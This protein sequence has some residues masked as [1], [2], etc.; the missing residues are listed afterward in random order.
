MAEGY[1]LDD[2]IS[3]PERLQKFRTDHPTWALRSETV[4]LTDKWVTVHAWVEDDK[5]VVVGDGHAEEMRKRFSLEQAETSAWGRA[6]AA[7]GYATS[8]A[9]ASR[10]EME[11][12]AEETSGKGAPAPTTGARKGRSSALK[13]S[14]RGSAPSADKCPH[15]H[16]PAGARVH[17]TNCPERA[18][19]SV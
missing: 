5:A 1:D 18:K 12:L 7:C 13:D 19:T 16:A 15:C 8:K 6:L 14:A 4:A 3:V 9:I 10:E 2:Y 11:R 17:G